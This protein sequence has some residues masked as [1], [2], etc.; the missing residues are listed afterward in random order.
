MLRSGAYVAHDDGFYRHL[1]PLGSTPRTDGPGLRSAMH[2]WVRVTS[3]PEPGLAL[4]DAGKRDLPFDEGL[5]RCS[6][7]APRIPGEQPTALDS[8]TVTAVN[9]QHG[10]LRFDPTGDPPL[11]IGTSCASGCPTPAP[12]STSGR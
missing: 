12:L 3:Q 5:P 9:D 7:A 8:V 10:F 2:A 11:E 6:C 1:S 4:I